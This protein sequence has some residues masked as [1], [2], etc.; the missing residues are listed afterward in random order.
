VQ[1]GVFAVCEA[2]TSTIRGAES[3]R[4]DEKRRCSE[5]VVF[6]NVD[7]GFRIHGLNVATDEKHEAMRH[8]IL[9]E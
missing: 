2:A 1:E 5:I 8:A 7:I 3:E 4:S 9:S 6:D